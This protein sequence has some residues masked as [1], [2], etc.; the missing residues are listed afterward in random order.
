M[1]YE[2]V[3]A[4]TSA[5]KE[6]EKKLYL[7]V[8]NAL[9]LGVIDHHQLLGEQKSATTLV[10]ENSYLIPEETQTIVLHQ[11]PDLDCIASS[12]LAKYFL[13]H[14]KFP[15]FASELT[16]FL[17]K[18]DFGYSLEN[19]VN[20]SSLFSIIKSKVRDEEELVNTGHQLIE[21]LAN[22]GFDSEDIPVQYEAEAQM[23]SDDST[24]YLE[25][26]KNSFTLECA[27][28]KRAKLKREKVKALVLD[29]PKSKLFKAWA[30]EEGFDLLIVKWSKKRTV[31]SLKA[32]SFYTLGGIG[33][34][35]NIKE[36]IKRQESNVEIKEENREGYEIP[37]PWYDGRAHNFTIIDAPRRGTSLSFE[38]ILECLR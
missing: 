36:K 16:L 20:L 17:D 15:S 30:R 9:H 12:Y 10:S 27:V 11:S 37:D 21:N 2:F 22:Y 35:L 19:R 38:E 32:D 29:K 7:D 3:A 14:K 1:T 13:T 26:K 23:I 25:D 4:G 33:D 18:S 24:V 28:Y 31:I 8:G 5:L 6:D 34:K